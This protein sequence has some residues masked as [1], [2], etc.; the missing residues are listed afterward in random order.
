MIIGQST[1]LLIWV[2]RIVT[3][4]TTKIFRNN[5]VVS[6]IYFIFVKEN[7]NKRLKN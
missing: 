5:F 7:Q 6:K 1:K 3:S 2:S 4:E